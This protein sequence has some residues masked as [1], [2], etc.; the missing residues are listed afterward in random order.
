[1]LR[2]LQAHGISIMQSDYSISLIADD[3]QE[4]KQIITILDEK[5]GLLTPHGACIASMRY[6]GASN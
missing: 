2:V 4:G 1:M 5:D 6:F 3:N